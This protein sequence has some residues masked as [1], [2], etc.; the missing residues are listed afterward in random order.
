MVLGVPA[1]AA[2]AVVRRAYRRRVRQTHPDLGGSAADFHRVQQAWE[3]L[4]G[5]R[6][7]ADSQGDAGEWS[8][9]QEPPGSAS[10]PGWT[11]R[12]PGGQWPVVS[13]TP[14]RHSW[15]G[16]LVYVLAALLVTV[17][18]VWLARPEP[19]Q[20]GLFGVT[21]PGPG[22]GPLWALAWVVAVVVAGFWVVRGGC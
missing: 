4:S 22:P 2:W 17:T 15:L 9:P 1:G 18:G 13:V 14:G 10:E 6:R 11:L 7:D 3:A 16:R 19:D 8:G 21:F 20:D 5:P 12:P